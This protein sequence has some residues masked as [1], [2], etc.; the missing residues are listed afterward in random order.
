VTTVLPTSCNSC[1]IAIDLQIVDWDPTT[2]PVTQRFRCPACKQ[3]RSAQIPG[4][5]VF[6]AKRNVPSVP[7]R[8]Q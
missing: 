2:T 4:I 1:G 8:K 7:L 3:E 6:V 5:L